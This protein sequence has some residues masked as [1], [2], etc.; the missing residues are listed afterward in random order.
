[1]QFLDA[2]QI[3]L[4]DNIRSEILSQNTDP[5]EGPMT[6][7]K[8]IAEYNSNVVVDGRITGGICRT[9]F[10]H[11]TMNAWRMEMMINRMI[12]PEMEISWKLESTKYRLSNTVCLKYEALMSG[13]WAVYTFR[14][15]Y[16]FF[17]WC[18]LPVPWSKN[19]SNAAPTWSQC[20][21]KRLN[22]LETF[23]SY[24]HKYRTEEI[25]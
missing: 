23:V 3:Q 10:R 19:I 18:G 25:I 21:E 24:F 16:Q 22:F 13:V 7:D 9:S 14:I 6:L 8:T 17:R 5:L 20:R 1:M 4:V 2:D 11:C 12:F 15:K